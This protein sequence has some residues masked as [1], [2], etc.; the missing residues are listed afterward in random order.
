MMNRKNWANWPTI[1]Q[2]IDTYEDFCGCSHCRV[3]Y[4]EKENTFMCETLVYMGYPTCDVDVDV[5]PIEYIEMYKTW[6][7]HTKW[8]ESGMPIPT[9]VTEVANDDAIDLPF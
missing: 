8:K 5:Y 4:Y 9:P 1:Q 2:L 7:A 6:V 3:I